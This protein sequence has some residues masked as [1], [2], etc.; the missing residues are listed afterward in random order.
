MWE[1]SCLEAV[2]SS[3]A[4]VSRR[5]SLGRRSVHAQASL[6]SSQLGFMQLLAVGPVPLVTL[7]LAHNSQAA[8]QD[9]SHLRMS[10]EVCGR[11]AVPRVPARGFVLQCAPSPGPGSPATA[12]MRNPQS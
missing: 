5:I 11:S 2:P 10:A 12:R 9:P 1:P 3:L 8:C 4:E 6:L 7:P